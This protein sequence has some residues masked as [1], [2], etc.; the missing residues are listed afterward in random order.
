MEL[1]FDYKRKIQFLLEHVDLTL[2]SEEQ[3]LARQTK[4]AK[5]K[6]DEVISLGKVSEAVRL[7]Q[8]LVSKKTVDY[9]DA[10]LTEGA[11][12]VFPTKQI[13]LYVNVGD[14]GTHKTAE[15]WCKENIGSHVVDRPLYNNFGG[16]LKVVAALL[17]QVLVILDRG[18]TRV[19]F[20]DESFTQV[21]HEYQEGL[22]DLLRLLITKFDFKILLVTQVDVFTKAADLIYY[23]RDGSVRRMNSY[24]QV[25]D[26]RNKDYDEEV[27]KNLT[28]E[29]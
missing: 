14:R 22:F 25:V 9:L 5:Q 6:A 24:R 19:L 29:V 16:G 23:M 13:S 18:N 15:I 7:L 1:L 3:N 12:V 4:E 20:L 11:K 21:S 2:A 26:E 8:E 27:N 10:F 28:E 17:L